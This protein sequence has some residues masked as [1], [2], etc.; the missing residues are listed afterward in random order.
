[1]KSASVQ[2]FTGVNEPFQWRDVPLPKSLSPGEVLVEM[3]L[4]TLCGSDLHTIEGRRSAPAPCV[5]GH[6]GVGRVVESH[7]AGVPVGQRITWTLAD[8]CGHC[9]ACSAWHLPQKC[10]RL[11]KYG[12]APWQE[13]TG[14]NGC[15]AT[16][17]LLRPG[18]TIVAVPDDLS[19]A[20]VAPANCA[21]ATVIHGLS[22]LPE[23][24]ERVLIQGSGL[25]G[26][27]A[28]M[29]LQC[30]GVREIY[31]Q[32]LSGD[33][34]ATMA[35]FGAVPWPLGLPVPPVDLVLELAGTAEVIPGGF[36]CL[37][38]GGHYVWAG[39]VH[40]Q[41]RLN[42]TG[43]AVVRKCVT[44]RGIHNYAPE[45]LTAGLA[46]LAQHHG[47][48][49]LESVVSPPLKLRQLTAAFDLTR[50]R[51]WLRVAVRP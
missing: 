28:S 47:R 4:A 21:L 20:L 36:E 25:L 33:R 29:W 15:Y 44:I 43:E 19:D 1:M 22:S 35:R 51:T 2:L 8:S 14:L 3:R 46:F 31:C 41:T 48:F 13:G 26:V 45:H 40:P 37:R 12:H 16:H 32:D 42:L 10:E 11:F 50:Q 49:P 27:Y 39:M 38:P 17:L 34:L 7:R 5:L 18:T 23:P 24:C 6:E 30:R 9:S